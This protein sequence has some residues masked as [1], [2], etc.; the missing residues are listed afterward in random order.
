MRTAKQVVTKGTK[1][2]NEIDL[3]AA[4][5]ELHVDVDRIERAIGLLQRLASQERSERCRP[6]HANS[7]S[8]IMLRSSPT[9]RMVF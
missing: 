2:T 6:A 5:S 8:I 9:T 4:S 7:V 3:D 1:I